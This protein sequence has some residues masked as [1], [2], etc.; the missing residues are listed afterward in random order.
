MSLFHMYGNIFNFFLKYLASTE[1]TIPLTILI[2]WSWGVRVVAFSINH[3]DSVAVE[4]FI[5]AHNVFFFSPLLSMQYLVAINTR[6]KRGLAAFLKL[7]Y[8][9]RVPISALCHFL[10]VPWV[11][12]WYSW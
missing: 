8:N 11:A 5:V 9:C 1:C 10:A 6:R 12:R 4:V 2:S 7:Y 3:H